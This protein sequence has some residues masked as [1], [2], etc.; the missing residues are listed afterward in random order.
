[1]KPFTLTAIV[2]LALGAVF[3]M[4]RFAS[5]WQV[6]VNGTDVPVWF[7]GIACIVAAVLAA[8]LWHENMHHTV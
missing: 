3:Q 2:L 6:T 5:D 1:M 4:V 7:S 8:M